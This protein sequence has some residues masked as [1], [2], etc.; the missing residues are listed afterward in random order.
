MKDFLEKLPPQIR[1][2]VEFRRPSW[3]SEEM[4]ALLRKADAALCQAESEKLETPDVQTA[5][6]CLFALA[7]RGYSAKERKGISDIVSKLAQRG[8]V[9]VYFKHE[10]TAG[11]AL[12]AEALLAETSDAEE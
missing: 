7:Q 8:D 5:S 10:E 2:A 11:G 3:F 1:A 4:Y 9:F 12:Y 6:F